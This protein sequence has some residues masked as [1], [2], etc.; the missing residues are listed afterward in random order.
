[1]VE[2]IG[3]VGLSGR[4]LSGSPKFICGRDRPQRDDRVLERADADGVLPAEL[5]VVGRPDGAVPA[6]AVDELHVEEVEVDRVRVHAVVRDLPDLRAVRRRPAQSGVIESSR[7]SVAGSMKLYRMK[8]GAPGTPA[9]SPGRACALM[10][11]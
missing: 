6:D 8:F 1:M 11:P 3:I 5:V 2:P 9:A 10:R 4:M 7:I